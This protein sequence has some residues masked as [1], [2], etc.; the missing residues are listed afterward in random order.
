MDLLWR[1]SCGDC[2]FGPIGMVLRSS[3]T[4]SRVFL[5]GKALLRAVF[6]VLTCLL[7]N[8]LDLGKS[9]EEV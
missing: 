9:G 5:A 6:N 7:M 1:I 3:R 4:D 8:L 2:F